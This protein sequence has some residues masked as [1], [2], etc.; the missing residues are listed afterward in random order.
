[1]G[2][3][4]SAPLSYGPS[5]P[6]ADAD[7]E[8]TR[9]QR[10]SMRP[11]AG[12]KNNYY[13][14]WKASYDY[15]WATWAEA[16]QSVNSFILPAA[17]IGLSISTASSSLYE[18]YVFLAA[19][20]FAFAGCSLV[21]ATAMKRLIGSVRVD[22]EIYTDEALFKSEQS[23]HSWNVRTAVYWLRVASMTLTTLAILCLFGAV[24]IIGHIKCVSFPGLA[25]AIYVVFILLGLVSCFVF[26]SPIYAVLVGPCFGPCW[27][28]WREEHQP[29]SVVPSP[30]A[31]STAPSLPDTVATLSKTVA[32]LSRTVAT[33][34]TTVERLAPVAAAAATTTAVRG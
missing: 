15:A 25:I 5:T 9:Q 4:P 34:S 6:N 22:I 7:I 30:S 2:A 17:F 20:A 23:L 13:R 27:H 26:W 14:Y 18:V 21:M 24:A 28:R 32:D 8:E 19:M 12:G 11:D 1:M 29:G 33:L 16:Q 3:Y 31:P 10:L